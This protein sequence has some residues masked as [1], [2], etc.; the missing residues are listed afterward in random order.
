MVQ[1]FNYHVDES[2]ETGNVAIDTLEFEKEW[3]A[4]IVGR[5]NHPVRPPFGARRRIL[6]IRTRTQQT[7]LTAALLRGA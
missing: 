6:P 4:A 7:T 5:G 1:H 2:G 3:T